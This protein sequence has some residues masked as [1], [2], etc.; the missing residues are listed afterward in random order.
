MR[1]EGEKDWDRI[2]SYSEDYR[3]RED[4][5]H[6]R[7]SES[8]PHF[9]RDDEILLQLGCWRSRR[10]RHE[11]GEVHDERKEDHEIER[12]YE[13]PHGLLYF[14]AD[15][16]TAR[17]PPASCSSLASLVDGL[18]AW[19]DRVHAKLRR[20]NPPVRE[21]WEYE[22]EPLHDYFRF[23]YSSRHPRGDDRFQ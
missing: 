13:T 19:R 6:V 10:E 18:H 5:D 2:Q 9:D 7:L 17:L 4:E 15:E 14:A 16:I 11:P 8:F 22:G 20:E 3:I 23:Q 1:G 21:P 12:Y